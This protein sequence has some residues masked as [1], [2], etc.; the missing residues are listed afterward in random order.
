MGFE[1]RPAFRGLDAVG[2]SN[3]L[4]LRAPHKPPRSE[5]PGHVDD[6]NVSAVELSIFFETERNF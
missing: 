5:A 4:V 6:K 1:G 2:M 3:S